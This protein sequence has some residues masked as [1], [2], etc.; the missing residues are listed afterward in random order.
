MIL[1]R[2]VLIIEKKLEAK[3]ISNTTITETQSHTPNEETGNNE[4]IERTF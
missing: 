3:L 2:I 4:N 1:V